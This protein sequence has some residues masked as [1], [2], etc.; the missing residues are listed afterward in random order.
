MTD[1]I[2]SLFFL[3]GCYYLIKFFSEAKEKFVLLSSVLF[4]ACSFVRYNGIIF[5]PIEILLVAGYF[6]YQ[7][8][9]KRE[10]QL[11]SKKL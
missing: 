4:V 5:F 1:S 3:L 7:G 2:F 9:I 10:N 6:L 11:N 8:L